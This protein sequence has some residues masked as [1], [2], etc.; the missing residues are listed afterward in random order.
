MGGLEGA[1]GDWQPDLVNKGTCDYES[2]IVNSTSY[3]FIGLIFVGGDL[4]ISFAK[5]EE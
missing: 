5:C 1:V 2:C 4:Y 3:K